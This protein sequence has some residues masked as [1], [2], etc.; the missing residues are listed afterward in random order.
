MLKLLRC[1]HREIY[2]Q[3]KIKN[4]LKSIYNSK[5]LIYLKKRVVNK[6]FYVY[7]LNIA[8]YYYMKKVSINHLNKITIMDSYLEV[9][10]NA[11]NRVV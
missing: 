1:N 9:L 5:Q 8:N 2:Y 6:F 7:K 10:N 11:Y 3:L 4:N